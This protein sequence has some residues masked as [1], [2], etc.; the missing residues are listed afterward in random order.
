MIVEQNGGESVVKA[1]AFERLNIRF[2]CPAT[3][4]LCVK[5]LY[6]IVLK[7][8]VEKIEQIVARFPSYG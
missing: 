1:K 6:S 2:I 8:V 4:C 3:C 5:I 7:C